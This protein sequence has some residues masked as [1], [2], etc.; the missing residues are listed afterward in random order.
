MFSV[1][2]WALMLFSLDNLNFDEFSH[3]ILTNMM[4]VLFFLTFLSAALLPPDRILQLVFTNLRN[5]PLST[6]SIDSMRDSIMSLY[7]N[8]ITGCKE[9]PIIPFKGYFSTR[10]AFKAFAKQEQREN[11][12]PGP[13]HV[14]QGVPLICGFYRKGWQTECSGQRRPA[15]LQL[16]WL[17]ALNNDSK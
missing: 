13:H 17:T 2:N 12:T 9:Y 3:V 11:N 5:R 8:L 4:N 1:W 15:D 6:D 16:V 10:L 7:H 14:Q